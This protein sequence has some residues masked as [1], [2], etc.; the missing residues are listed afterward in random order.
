LNLLLKSSSALVRWTT[1]PADSNTSTANGHI[2][3]VPIR[4]MNPFADTI[5]ISAGE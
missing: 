1:A 3:V 4:P 5:L 2:D